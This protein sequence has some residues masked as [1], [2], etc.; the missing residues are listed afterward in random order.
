MIKRL[1]Y[2][3]FEKIKI[4]NRP[5]F[6]LYFY[7]KISYLINEKLWIKYSGSKKLTLSKSNS[8]GEKFIANGFCK[9]PKTNADS[10]E[11]F[12]DYLN[13]NFDL[14][15]GDSEKSQIEIINYEKIKNK[16]LFDFLKTPEIYK[17]LKS[18]IGYDPMLFGASVI[19]SNPT[20]SHSGSQLFHFDNI[21]EKSIRLI[22]LLSDVNQ[23]NGP[24]TIIS[25]D[26]SATIAQAVNY[27][28]RKDYV[29]ITDEEFNIQHEE[30]IYLTGKKGDIFLLDTYGCLHSGGRT[31][32]GQRLV[33]MATIGRGL[34]T[35]LRWMYNGEYDYGI[36]I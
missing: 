7:R 27:F 25:K 28:K 35:N 16:F 21:E 17:L 22:L 26:K 23:K 13:K 12:L 10:V 24:T 6:S 4:F 14:T 32:E 33:F 15:I 34:F 11:R 31:E 36:K 2:Y 8:L 20:K 30:K 19:G 29:S 18:Y 9:I 5:L 3:F 1:I